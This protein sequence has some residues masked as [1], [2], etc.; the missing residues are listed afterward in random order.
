MPLPEFVIAIWVKPHRGFGY[1][2]EVDASNV[3]DGLPGGTFQ[4]FQHVATSQR[5]PELQS[6]Y[7]N[8]EFGVSRKQVEELVRLADQVNY[9]LAERPHT[10][11]LGGSFF[12]LRVERGF[13]ETAIVWHGKFEDQEPTIC[14]LYAA[15]QS[16]AE[17]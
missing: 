13:H 5:V 3:E 10:P 6:D 2:I 17:A 9:S 16:L 14:N 12:G 4:S 15:V 11:V 7:P 8:R 1:Y